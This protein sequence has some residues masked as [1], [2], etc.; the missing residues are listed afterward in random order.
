MPLVVIVTGRQELRPTRCSSGVP[1]LNVYPVDEKEEHIM[2]ACCPCVPRTIMENGIPI[3]V[4]R[5]H[6][7]HEVIVEA[8]KLIN[9]TID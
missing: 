9:K 2:D 7:A 4:H 5:S 6:N 8:E 3:I 1:M